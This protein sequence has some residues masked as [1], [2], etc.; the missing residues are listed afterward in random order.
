MVGSGSQGL[1][2]SSNWLTGATRW[3]QLNGSKMRVRNPS[4]DIPCTNCTAS[5]ITK[6]TEV[7]QSTKVTPEAAKE[8]DEMRV[9]AMP[10]PSSSYFT[11]ITKSKDKREKITVEV[12]DALGRIVETISMYA[13]ETIRLG[14]RYRPGL[15]IVRFVQGKQA[16][17]LK[18]VKSPG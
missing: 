11:I 6:T 13:D 17:Q 7:D 4:S 16:I 12:S 1:I 15:Y 2:F 14:D 9:V 10:N 8:S 18:L 5:S 3:Q